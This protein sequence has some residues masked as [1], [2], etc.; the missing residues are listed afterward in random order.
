[1]N[2]SRNER[3]HKEHKVDKWRFLDSDLAEERFDKLNANG[4]GEREERQ[5]RI[6]F[7]SLTPIPDSRFPIP[8]SDSR[9]PIPDSRFAHSYSFPR[10]PSD[11]SH[12]GM[13]AV[14]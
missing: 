3:S 9:F 4:R 11:H 1:M 12:A 14:R 2:S 6:A 10:L 13:I 8:D 5:T 7:Y